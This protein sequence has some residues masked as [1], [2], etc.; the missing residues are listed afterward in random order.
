M[1]IVSLNL[2]LGLDGDVQVD[3]DLLILEVIVQSIRDTRSRLGSIIRRLVENTSFD[4]D[5][6]GRFKSLVGEF[7]EFLDFGIVEF[8]GFVE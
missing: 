5:A 8:V 2:L 7:G 3:L 1:R 4:E 6:D